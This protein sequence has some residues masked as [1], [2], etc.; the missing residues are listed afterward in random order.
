MDISYIIYYLESY[1][2]PLSHLKVT[3]IMTVVR[4]AVVHRS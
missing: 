2:K 1:L 4:M 3:H